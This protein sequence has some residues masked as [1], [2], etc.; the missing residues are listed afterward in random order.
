MRNRIKALVLVMVL[1]GFAFGCSSLPEVTV[2][3]TEAQLQE[4]LNK[5]FPI[6]KSHQFLGTLSYEN[7]SVILRREDNRVEF[8]LEISVSNITVNNAA[9]RC[10]AV[11]LASV[12]YSPEKKALFLTKPLLQQFI[13]N[14][15]QQQDAQSLSVL[16]MPALEKLLERKPVYRLKDLEGFEKIASMLVK[17]IRVRDGCIEIVWGV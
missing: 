17:D 4:Y 2:R 12:M 8:G 5:K 7:P 3:I 16:F 9:L 6:T 15:A 1:A 11:M 14:G 13:L 10:S